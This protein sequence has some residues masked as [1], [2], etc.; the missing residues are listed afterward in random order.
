[1][2][3][4]LKRGMEEGSISPLR[5]LQEYT[6]ACHYEIDPDD[7]ML[8]PFVV[9]KLDAMEDPEE[10]RYLRMEYVTSHLWWFSQGDPRKLGA[11]LVEQQLCLDGDE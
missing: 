11:G 5:Y 2:V 7:P 10:R 9:E 4:T 3:T 1:V 8:C 6:D